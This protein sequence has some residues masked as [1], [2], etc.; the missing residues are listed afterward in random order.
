VGENTQGGKGVAYNPAYQG[1]AIT[2][3][4]NTVYL[5]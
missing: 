1:I 3:N 4:G 2:I 5:L